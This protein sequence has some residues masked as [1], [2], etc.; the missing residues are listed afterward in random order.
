[1]TKIGIIL[2]STRPG[3]NGKAVADWVFQ[4]ASQRSD[5]EFE[6]VD[7][8]DYPLPH[9]DEPLP[10]SLRQ[11][12]GEHTKRWAAKI[13]SFDGFVFVTPEYNHSTSGVLKNAIDYLYAEW[14]N[15]ALGI[16]SYGGVGGARAAEHL[17]LIA[18]ELQMADV[19]NQVTLSLMTE[20]ENFSVFKPGAYQLPALQSLLDQL[21]AW[22]HALAPL[23]RNL[24]V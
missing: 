9:L 2:G 21:V 1:M 16:V 22:S 10:P 14:N 24:A 18:G 17:R 13:A 19:R 4:I 15:K 3:R 23:R 7:L 11:Y 5:A 12:Q 6:L 20:F 8:L